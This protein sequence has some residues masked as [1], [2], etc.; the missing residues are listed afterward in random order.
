MTVATTPLSPAEQR[1]ISIE[2]IGRAAAAGLVVEVDPDLADVMAAFDK[3]ALDAGE[4]DASRLDA[5]SE[6]IV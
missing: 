1:A 6:E 5:I 4:A 2:M 3:P